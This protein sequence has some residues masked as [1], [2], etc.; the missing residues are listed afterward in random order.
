M[1]LS[2]SIIFSPNPLKVGGEWQVV[3]QYPSGQVEMITGFK[4]EA[5]AMEWIEKDS[6]AWVKKR[7]YGDE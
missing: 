3:A 1:A 2:H 7:A 5:E 6:K 4:T